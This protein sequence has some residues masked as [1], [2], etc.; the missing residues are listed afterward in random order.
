MQLEEPSGSRE[1][2]ARLGLGP[3]AE[4]SLRALA[5]PGA[6]GRGGKLAGSCTKS[7]RTGYLGVQRPFLTLWDCN[8]RIKLHL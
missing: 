8:Y 6:W 3:G 5:R 1:T 4:P 7:L 2:P